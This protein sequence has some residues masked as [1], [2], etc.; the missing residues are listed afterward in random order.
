MEKKIQKMLLSVFILLNFAAVCYSNR[1]ESMQNSPA[2]LKGS[3]WLFAHYSHFTGMDNRWR[4]FSRLNRFNWWYTIYG[5]GEDG[6]LIKLPLPLQ[7]ERSL[8]QYLW[9]DF[10]IPK[11]HLNM[12]LKPWA[13]QQYA[14]F[15][16]NS[17]STQERPF[18]AV[19]FELNYQNIL[20]I[21]KA[22]AYHTHLEEK[23]NKTPYGHYPCPS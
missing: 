19:V 17:L 23:V 3:E 22:A 11:F 21:A 2:N 14:N 4:M 15:L 13:R 7:R 16:C 18:K 5:E 6:H 10:K 1:P 9:R 12:Y 8:Y 20:P